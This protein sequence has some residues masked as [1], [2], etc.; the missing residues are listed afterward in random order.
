MKTARGRELLTPEQRQ[1]FMQ[2]SE[3]EWV[4]GTYYTFSKRDLEIINKRRREENRLGFAVQLAILRYPGW[5]YT[6]IKSIPDSVIH[7]ISKQIGSTPSS[8]SLYP[9]RENTLWDHLKE[10]RTEYDL[11]TFTLKEYRMTFKH[12]YQLALE[13]GDAIHL[14]HECIDFLRKNKIILPAITTLERMVWEAREMA[15]KKLFNMVSQSLSN[16]QKEKLEEIITSQHPSES[17][18]TILGWLKEPP[19]HP[20]PE[21][22]LK[23]IERLEYIRG[24]ELETVQI[25]HLHRNR[26]LQLSRLGSRYE[27]YAFRDFQENKRYS[28]LTVYLLHLTQELTDKAFEIHD[29][30]ILSLLSKGR[31]AQEEIQK[32]NGK[33]L[34]EK[35]IHFTNIG[36][37][38]IKAKE[39]KLDA[40]EVLESVIE[41]NSFVSSVVE[42]QEL[43]RPADY[44]YLDLLQKRFYTLRK[45]TP[46]LLRVLEFDSTKANEPLLQA[47]EIIRR[48]NESGK[49]KV[50]DE[51]PVDFISKRWK[52][53]LYGDDGTINRHYY[54]MAVLTELREHVRAGDVSIVGS[55]QY[56]DFEE[57]LFSEDTWNQTKEN[58]R[59]SVSLSSEDYL[60]ERT[61]SLNER[62]KWLSAN[63]NKLDGV[64]LEKGKLSISR[65]EKDTPEEAKK[66]SA[67]LYQ[68]LPRIKLTDLL[69]DVAYITRFHEQF[70]HASNNRKPDKEETIIIMAALLGMGMNI[71]LSKMADAT[72]G[73]TYKQLANVSQWRMYEDAM[74]KAQAVLV[75]FHHKLQ[76]SS[77][78]GDGT[79]SSSDGMRMQLGVS[80]LHAD[81]NPHYGTGKGATIYRFTSDQFSS[82]YTKII[83]TNSRD[84]IH[85]L[86]GLLHH[87]TDLNI[88]EHYTDTAGYTDQIFGLTHLL[89]FKFAPR[90][91]DLSDSKL[92][93]I[94]KASEYPKLEAILRG[95]IN[96]KVIEEN[97]EDVLR[98]A[99]SIREG[100]VSA[101]LI[102]GK[103]GSYSRQNSL[104]TALREMGRIEK[105]IFILNYI[106]DESLRRKI[107][108]GLNKGEAMN[109]LARAIFFGKQ[110]ELRE[111]TIQHQLQRASA[112]NIIINAISIWNT[113]HLTKAVEYQKRSDSFN[114]ELLHHMSPLGWE[115]INLLGE[116]HFNSEKMISLDSLRPLKLS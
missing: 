86:D 81:A 97:Y 35:V 32:Q 12:L 95:Q 20:S 114:E 24:M 16:T 5:P 47:V 17:N 3:D 54:E 41:W 31:K 30:Q 40:F 69:M 104:A 19:G 67:S 1:A 33:K 68:M 112:L 55:R 13:N 90:I 108:R 103:L 96:T 73:L 21:T 25:N 115:H 77:Y 48:M 85:V 51:S 59:L 62:L 38:L 116:Y 2:I 87:E 58:T 37:A 94:D 82:Y 83:Y 80:S 60:T 50:P 52:K 49:R 6:H 53:H 89:G 98:L 29:R 36:Q 63:F 64:S 18:K 27:P 14:L 45:Y 66:F 15:E 106:S 61:S 76:L 102:M 75:N 70:T 72:P 43:A 105:T 71:G 26:L 34:N 79:T 84:A 113:L 22:F 65:L 42:A 4:L 10:I 23:L 44:D 100:T 57:Y 88:E 92:F 9:Q 8:L 107:Q 7:Y 56:R 74:N 93:T 110:G 101:S 91:R 111:R 109:G 28:I 99:H 11:V 39:E 78:W 46:T